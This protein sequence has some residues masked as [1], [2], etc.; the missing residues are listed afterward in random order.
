MTQDVVFYI[1]AGEIGRFAVEGFCGKV[2][3][4]FFGKIGGAGSAYAP[5]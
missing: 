2:P 1:L 5:S 4:R 3:F